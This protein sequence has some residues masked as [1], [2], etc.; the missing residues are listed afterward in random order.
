MKSVL[1]MTK[2]ERKH[3]LKRY[4]GGFAM[5][6]DAGQMVTGELEQVDM[7]DGSVLIKC[8]ERSQWIDGEKVTPSLKQWKDLTDEDIQ[9]IIENVT[10]HGKRCSAGDIVRIARRFDRI[11]VHMNDDYLFSPFFIFQ[12]WSIVAGGV[13]IDNIGQIIFLLCELGYDVT[14]IFHR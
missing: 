10:F 14:G 6:L 8:G 2:L 11:I 12:N 9:T 4:V 5:V 1:D 13:P 7:E 3:Y